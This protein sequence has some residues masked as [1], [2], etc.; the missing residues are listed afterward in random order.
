MEHSGSAAITSKA[1]TVLGSREIVLSR[2]TLNVM[3]ES[4][5]TYGMCLNQLPNCNAVVSVSSSD[6]SAASVA[7]ASRTF[8]RTNWNTA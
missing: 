6:S 7:P 1:L 3:E 8:S 4:S 2:S 5:G